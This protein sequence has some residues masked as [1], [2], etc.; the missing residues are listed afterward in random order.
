MFSKRKR[1]FS[2]VGSMALAA[3]IAVNGLGLAA[4]SVSAQEAKN[5]VVYSNS[6]SNGR[7]EWL[8][9]KASEAGYELEF[10]SAGGDEIYNRVLAEKSAPQADVVF[11]LDESFFIRMSE[12]E[13]LSAYEPIWA[14][15]LPENTV[16]SENG[17]FYPLVEQHVF[18]MYNADF[19]DPAPETIQQLATDYPQLY[20]AP[21]S[22][23]GNTNQKALLSLLLQYRDDAGELGISEEGWAQVEAFI[24]NS[25]ELSEGEDNLTLFADGTKP[26]DYWYSS[27]IAEAEETYGFTATPLLPETGIMTFREQVAI[28]NQGA[29]AD[30]SVAQEFVDWF[31]SAEVQGEW[32]TE[33]GTVPV[34]EAAQGSL[35]PRTQELVSQFVPMDVDWS[36]VNEYLSEW[37]EKI[38]LEIIPF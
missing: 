6:V 34:L 16:T 37:I 18:F 4:T 14:A 28:V 9:A 2:K 21:F 24:T 13:L 25:Y 11:G 35:N 22:L 30:T 38:E 33:F 23:G 32:A 29:D 26:I 1:S 31:G 7:D 3:L 8:A 19:V 5:L 15:E 10:V 27:G 17:D 36:F 20:R 12:D